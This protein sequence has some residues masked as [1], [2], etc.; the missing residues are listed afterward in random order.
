MVRK[1]FGARVTGGADGAGLPPLPDLL[2]ECH[3]TV[4]YHSYW[5]NRE[6][7]QA[8]LEARVMWA[9]ERGYRVDT[10]FLRTESKPFWVNPNHHAVVVIDLPSQ[11]QNW[12]TA[13]E[14]GIAF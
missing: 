8:A 12:D 4:D 3:S 14:P 11:S 13:Q 6:R 2:P 1:T 10:S 7:L 5:G 9:Q